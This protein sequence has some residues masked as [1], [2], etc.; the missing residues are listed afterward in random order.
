[1]YMYIL[2]SDLMMIEYEQKKKNGVEQGYSLP[3]KGYKYYHLFNNVLDYSL[4][5]IEL[6]NYIKHKITVCE[7]PSVKEIKTHQQKQ[8]FYRD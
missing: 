7:I 4:D 1:M 3:P 2:L 8:G 6:E 5:L